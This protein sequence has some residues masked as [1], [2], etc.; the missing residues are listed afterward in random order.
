MKNF[1][2][3]NLVT[4][5]TVHICH[6]EY[7]T[8]LSSHSN[9]CQLVSTFGKITPM[10]LYSQHHTSIKL[11]IASNKIEMGMLFISRL[12][13]LR[14]EGVAFCGFSWPPVIL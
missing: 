5:V 3:R 14:K 1:K 6:E 8:M 2:D 11:I 7:L 12:V 9:F 10:H 4:E 13:T